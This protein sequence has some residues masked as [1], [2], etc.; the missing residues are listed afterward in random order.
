MEV[1]RGGG[2]GSDPV[3]RSACP[4]RCVGGLHRS[5]TRAPQVEEMRRQLA[6]ARL[7]AERASAAAAAAA[8]KAKNDKE[9]RL[10][11]TGDASGP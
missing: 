8:E 6:A 2:T 11:V 9:V 3:K 5:R 10:T 7:E 4:A 1:R